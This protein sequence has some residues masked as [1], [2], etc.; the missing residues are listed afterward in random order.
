MRT[1]ITGA[2]GHLGRLVIDALL[3]RGVAIPGAGSRSPHRAPPPGEV[4]GSCLPERS[5]EPW[6]PKSTQHSA[7][8]S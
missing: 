5:S 6:P 7:R 3:E 4:L 8:S 2:G 1:A